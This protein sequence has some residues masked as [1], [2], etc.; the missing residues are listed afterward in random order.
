MAVAMTDRRKVCVLGATGS[1]GRA[2]CELLAEAPDRFEATALTGNGN[3]T[4]MIELARLVQPKFVAAADGSAMATNFGCTSRASSIIAV[5]L[6]LPVRAVASNRS[7]AS[8][9]NSQVA[10]PTEPVAPRTQTFR[11]SVIATAIQANKDR[12]QPGRRPAD[13]RGGPE[14]RHDRESSRRNLCYETGA[15]TGIRRDRR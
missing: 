1:V 8:A 4:A 5:A 2:T 14:S 9:S 7:G 6:P 3:A 13:C 10:R 12:P 15:S 11:R